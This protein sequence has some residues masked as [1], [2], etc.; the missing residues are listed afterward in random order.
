MCLILAKE[1]GAQ[2][3]YD[4]IEQAVLN[5]P[6]GWGVVIPQ[7]P[8]P[9]FVRRFLN[10]D[11]TKPDEVLKF[12]DEVGDQEL[13]LHLR[14]TT[15]GETSLS[16]CHPFQVTTRRSHGQQ[17]Y[18]MHNGT[19][20]DYSSKGSDSDTRVFVESYVRPLAERFI[21]HDKS[22]TLLGDS[23]FTE[24]ID[25][26]IPVSNKVLMIDEMGNFVRMGGQGEEFKDKNG[27]KWWVSNTYSFK[28]NYRTQGSYSSY[29][30][31]N[32]YT[33]KWNHK[34]PTKKEEVKKE[35]SY[36]KNYDDWGAIETETLQDRWGLNSLKELTSLTHGDLHEIVTDYP[37]DASLMLVGLLAEL[38]KKGKE[39]NGK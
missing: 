18:L 6:D 26:K 7:Y 29:G 23:L 33:N 1:T 28:P 30:S 12:L 25:L 2:L 17:V 37:E 31:Y 15:K 27:K 35:E 9:A 14:F 21:A 32:V 24:V 5:N 4:K 10:K 20:N 16:N 36:L 19:L 8:N 34:K 3:D 22:A 13:F 38:Y 11:G 39:E